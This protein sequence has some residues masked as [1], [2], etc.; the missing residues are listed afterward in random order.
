MRIDFSMEVGHMKKRR[1]GIF[2]SLMKGLI[3]AVAATLLG[4]LIMSTAVIFLGMSDGAIRITNQLLKIIAAFLGTFVAVGRGGERGL[5]TGAALGALYASAGY[6]M[7]ICLG[8][9]N[10]DPVE[11]MGEMTICAA[12][13]A[14]S[15]VLCANMKKR[16]KTA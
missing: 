6:V 11:L 2:I 3:A 1:L 12:A 8:G 13:G 16:R 7:Y 14:V 15:G 9:G 10:F 4:M 5:V